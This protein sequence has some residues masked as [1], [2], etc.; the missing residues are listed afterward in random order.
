MIIFGG[1]LKHP[2]D[3]FIHFSHK[4]LPTHKFVNTNVVKA[5][6]YLQNVGYTIN[7]EVLKIILQRIDLGF[8]DF[9]PLDFHPQTHN[10]SKLRNDK[11]F[12]DYVLINSI[13]KS[14]SLVY[15]NKDILTKALILTEVEEFFIPVFIDWRG[16]YYAAT[17]PFS[18]QGGDLPKALFMFSKG[19]ILNSRGLDIMKL[20]AGKCYGYKCYGL[21][22]TGSNFYILN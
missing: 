10:L 21:N 5:I 19:D 2:T 9:I 20:Y 14:N 15:Y 11:N 13:I 22:K 17:S 8:K 6:N 3:H 12:K 7:K 18:Y 1:L 4:S 16:R